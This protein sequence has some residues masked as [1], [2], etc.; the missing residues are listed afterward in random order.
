VE[1]Q[2][3]TGVLTGVE[4]LCGEL[5]EAWVEAQRQVAVAMQRQLAQAVV[6]AVQAAE[7][8][9]VVTGGARRGRGARS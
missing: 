2:L 3:T 1:Q 7:Q 5:M 6:G 4:G 8:R 9:Q